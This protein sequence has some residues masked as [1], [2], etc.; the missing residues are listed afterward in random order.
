[1]TLPDAPARLTALID[2]GRTLLVEAGA[3]SGKT[4]LMAGRVAVML[5]AGVAPRDIVAI[6]FTE[7]AA[8]ELLE[9]I[10]KFASQLQ[11]GKIPTELRQALASPL[12]PEQ[13]ENIE[14]GCRTLDEITCTTIHGFCQ[15][16][17]RPYPVETGVDPGAQIIDPAAAELAFHD[18]MEAWLSARF[19][20]DRSA[21]GLGRIP[22]MTGAGGEDDFFAELVNISP[23]KAVSL[24]EK[25]ADFLKEH[26]TATA[27]SQ[28]PDPAIFSSLVSAV[29]DFASWYNGCGVVEEKTE[30]VVTDLARV[31]EIAR[32]LVGGPISGKIIAQMLAHKRPSACKSDTTD[33]KTWGKKT[34]WKDAAKAA[35]KSGPFG[36]TLS[37][38][39]EA[40]YWNCDAAYGAFCG[41]L[42][43]LAFHRFVA[44]FD[45][46]KDIYARYKRDAALM[47]FD[48]LLHHAK[49][50]L[51]NSEPV[52]QALA[53]RYPRIL[54][55]E[56][57]DTDPLQAEILWRLAGEG[58]QGGAWQDRKIRPGALFLVGDPKQ[59]IYRF[60]GADV[61]TYLM[62]KKAL[63]DHDPS[64]ILEISANFRSQPAILQFVNDNFADM[65]DVAQGQ[66]GFS[67]L[68]PVR[69]PGEQPAVATFDIIIE[70]RHRNEKGLIAKELRREESKIVAD[71]VQRLIGSYPVWDKDLGDY[72]TAG[73]GDIALLAPTGT[74]LWLYERALENRDISIATQAGKGFFNRQE[75]QDLIAVAR[76][77]SDRRDT[78]AL[79][80]LLR[81]PVVGLTEEEIADEILHLQG[82][83]GSPRP[84]HLWTNAEQV[85]NPILKRTLGIL[86]NLARKARR[87]TPHQLMAEAVEE[88]KIRPILKARYRRGAERALANVEL[89]LEMARPYAARGIAEFSRAM[90][91]RWDDT[92][93][94]AEGRPDAEVD[95]VSIVTMHSSKGLEWP[96]V[97]PINSMTKLFSKDQFLYRRQDD[98][99]HFAVLDFAS[100]DYDAVKQA[101]ADE[102]RRERV[103]LW[104][105]ALTRARDLLLL[106]LQSERSNDDWLSLLT[107]DLA[108]APKFDPSTFTGKAV[109]APSTAANAQDIKTWQAEAAAIVA[110][111]RTITW[112]QPSRHEQGADH[113]VS[114]FAIFTG[115][116]AVAEQ[117]PDVETPVI[118]GGRER[119]LV[120]HKLIEEVLTGETSEAEDALQARAAELLAEMGLTDNPEPANGCNSAELAASVLRGLRLPEIVA[121][122]P[123][124]RPEVSIFSS[125]ADGANF[126]MTSGV[127]DALALG[128]DGSIDMVVDWKSDVEPD[129]KTVELYRGQVRDYL[130]ATSA[131]TGLIVFLTPGR[132]EKIS[133]TTGSATTF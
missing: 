51:A 50:L 98:S 21:E 97:I 66:P 75:V 89:V 88:L 58:T 63:A 125:V 79:G 109:A 44:E 29:E 69:Q 71:L 18:L 22:P 90:W 42:G 6:T 100:P 60:R 65:L 16:L 102:L 123:L 118:Q 25:A 91:E 46:L 12:S 76:A 72:R 122:R 37:A 114:E 62:A 13:R 24:I 131:Q 52:R 105:V 20:R 26:R 36:E 121:L 124:L 5:T 106:P 120:L 33:F 117:P 15:Q 40:H 99:V 55:D 68:A 38:A 67:A 57:Q 92:E 34:K 85:K 127:A 104:Y 8:S 83:I 108:S 32:N 95:A 70:D 30:E 2:H 64:A 103:R 84:L 93:S 126:E 54:V 41:A 107:L 81:G 87:A 19:G 133:P 80:A 4:A 111:E 45:T 23:D 132:V 56:F 48:D 113:P 9:R 110:N 129:A 53:A 128:P 115:P 59:A 47:D 35:G 112:R 11:Q 74:S 119:G 39:G 3:G 77:I 94:Q 96:I 73:A 49:D 7:A 61:A 43:Q 28:T 130:A 1:M 82:A 86:Q 10:E 27:P 14:S 31:A 116:E 101:E 78:L 17:V